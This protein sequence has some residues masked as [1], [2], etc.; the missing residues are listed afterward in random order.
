[1]AEAM[2]MG[3]KVRQAPRPTS[4]AK[5]GTT[6]RNPGR[7][8]LMK[9]PTVPKRRYC[10]SISASAR[11]ESSRR[12]VWVANS[13]RPYFR[14]ATYTAAAPNRLAVQV[15]RNTAAGVVNPRWERNAPSATAASDG[16]GGTTFSTAASRA[17]TA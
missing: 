2:A 12:P 10:R 15:T 11:G 13:F 17:R 9:M 16:T 4:P 6:A 1:M 5:G 7:N 14:A 3:G 8:L